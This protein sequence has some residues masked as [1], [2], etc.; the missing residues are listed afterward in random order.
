[1][2]QTIAE[3]ETNVAYRWFLGYGLNNKIL[4]FTTF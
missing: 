2:R 4:N 3:I 1:M